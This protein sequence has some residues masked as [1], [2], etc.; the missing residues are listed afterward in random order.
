MIQDGSKIRFPFHA[1]QAFGSAHRRPK[2]SADDA[3]RA[4][5]IVKMVIVL[6][7]FLFFAHGG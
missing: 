3:E 7:S 4:G 1:N 6:E 5:E 2:A